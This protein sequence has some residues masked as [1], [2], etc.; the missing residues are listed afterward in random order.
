MLERDEKG[1]LNPVEEINGKWYFWEETGL[2]IKVLLR[3]S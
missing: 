3:T 2:I 1:R